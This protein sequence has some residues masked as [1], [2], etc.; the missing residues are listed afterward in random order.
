MKIGHHSIIDTGGQMANL[1]E[2]FFNL[3]LRK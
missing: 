2:K 3:A 1:N